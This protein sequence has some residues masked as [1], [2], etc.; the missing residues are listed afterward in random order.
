MS[1]TPKMEDIQTPTICKKKSIE[2]AFHKNE[3][4]QFKYPVKWNQI[5]LPNKLLNFILM[6][7]ARAGKDAMKQTLSHELGGKQFGNMYQRL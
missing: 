5:L 1:D 2:A 6:L 4:I 3:G 7:K